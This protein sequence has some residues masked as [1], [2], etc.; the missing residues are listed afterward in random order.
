MKP[1]LRSIKPP[2]IDTLDRTGLAEYFVN[3]WELYEL[4]FSSIQAPGALFVKPDPLRQPLIFY[5]GH[6]AAFYT[7]KLKLAGLIGRGI[8]ERFEQLFAVGV[9]P[10]AAG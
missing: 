10:A 5:L 7:N 9:D 6:T 4:L 8:D 2:R 3:T 1:G